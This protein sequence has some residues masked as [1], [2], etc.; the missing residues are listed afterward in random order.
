[1]KRETPSPSEPHRHSSSRR[2]PTPR[3]RRLLARHSAA[4]RVHF[5]SRSLRRLDHGPHRLPQ[6]RRHHRAVADI[7]NHCAIR[8]QRTTG[9]RRPHRSIRQRIGIWRR[10]RTLACRLYSACPWSLS[11]SNCR[12]GCIGLCVFVKVQRLS[13]MIGRTVVQILILRFRLQ[14]QPLRILYLDI[15]L[16]MKIG[17]HL[18]CHSLEHRRRNLSALVQVRWA[19][20]T[21]PRS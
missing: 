4:K 8:R 3:R 11:L 19:N 10:N 9:T 13:R 2:K 18:R 5:D 1:M 15:V 17:Q 6:E 21:R 20:P 7:E 12:R 16:H 14:Q